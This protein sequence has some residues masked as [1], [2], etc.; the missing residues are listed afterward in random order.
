MRIFGRLFGNATPDHFVI[1]WYFGENG[2]VIR[3]VYHLHKGKKVEMEEEGMVWT[4]P[5][6]HA[7]L[8]MFG[9]REDGDIV[10]QFAAAIRRRFNLFRMEEGGDRWLSKEMKDLMSDFFSEYR[11]FINFPSDEN[12]LNL[13]VRCMQ[14]WHRLRKA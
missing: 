7:M 13:A 8:E 3:S 11:I 2:P 4:C 14:L 9:K 10:S 1:S 5:K 6:C 12:V